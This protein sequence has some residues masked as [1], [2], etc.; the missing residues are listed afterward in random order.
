MGASTIILFFAL[1]DTYILSKSMHTCMAPHDDMKEHRAIDDTGRRE[2]LIDEIGDLAAMSEIY[3]DQYINQQLCKYTGGSERTHIT[4]PR[5]LLYTMDGTG[6]NRSLLF[7]LVMEK[8]LRE[9]E[10]LDRRFPNIM[11]LLWSVL[12]IRRYKNRTVRDIAYSKHPGKERK[13]MH[14]HQNFV[15]R[16]GKHV[17]QIINTLTMK[18][19][20]S[21]NWIKELPK[22]K[23][24][25]PPFRRT[26]VKAEKVVRKVAQPQ[27]DASSDEDQTILDRIEKDPDAAL[28]W[29]HENPDK[30][31]EM[32]V[33]A[34]EMVLKHFGLTPGDIGL[35]DH[36]EEAR[37]DAGPEPDDMDPADRKE[38]ERNMK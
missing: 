13:D 15:K 7:T 12:R 1:C 28:E 6:I 36:A 26:E 17:T 35:E 34:R 25:Q 3:R 31:R 27:T 21:V 9:N 4:V 30:I 11:D 37:Q 2:R 23:V 20:G 19:P 22:R 8:F 32:S 14:Q 29:I 16:H 18:F 24:I 33:T 5:Y 10:Y 38:Y